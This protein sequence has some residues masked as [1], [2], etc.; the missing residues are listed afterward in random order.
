VTTVFAIR[1]AALLVPEEAIV[2]QGGRQFVVRVV[3][4]SV[5]PGTATAALPSDITQ[6]SQRLEV[7]L[8]VRRAGKV[9]IEAM[10][11]SAASAASAPGVATAVLPAPLKEGDTIVTA[12]QQRL[13]RDG[14]PVR[15]V[16]LARPGGPQGVGASAAR[17]VA[18]VAATASG[19]V[20]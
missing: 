20:R 6:V 13:Q 4:R 17:P 9:E 19:V 1:E 15:V 18:S 3:D 14:S 5:V 10:P 12:G 2:P 7:K 16:D 8:G 11:P